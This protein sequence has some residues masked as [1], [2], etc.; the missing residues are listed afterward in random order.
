MSKLHP[1][2]LSFLLILIFLAPGFLMAEDLVG[3]KNLSWEEQKN[4]TKIVLETTK[5]LVYNVTSAQSTSEVQVELANLDLRNM[6]QE[7]FINTNEVVS[8]QTFPQTTGQNAKII[9]KLSSILPYEV[10]TEGSNLYIEIMSKGDGDGLLAPA[11]APE[12]GSKPAA[13]QPAATAT[14]APQVAEKQEAVQPE[15]HRSVAEQTPA[16]TPS[17]TQSAQP[18]IVE[19]KKVAPATEVRDVRIEE[20]RNAGLVGQVREEDRPQADH[21]PGR[22]LFLRPALPEGGRCCGDR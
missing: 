9:L 10:K 1:C 22:R 11:P 5:P 3:I 2:L 15:T 21:G 18:P 6:P 16:A 13:E 14:P 19:L 17:D 4:R 12:Q 20:R 7:L 8:L